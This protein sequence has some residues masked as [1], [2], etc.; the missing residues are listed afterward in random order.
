MVLN[1]FGASKKNLHKPGANFRNI[2]FQKYY[3]F[4]YYLQLL[5]LQFLSR[6]YLNFKKFT[7][8]FKI[9]LFLKSSLYQSMTVKMVHL[10]NK[11]SYNN[12]M[13]I[14]FHI[15]RSLKLLFYILELVEV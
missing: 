2:L 1:F 6:T 12:Q 8:G 9:A 4:N 5:C 15:Y 3:T 11:T 13:D 10:Q 14:I 7:F